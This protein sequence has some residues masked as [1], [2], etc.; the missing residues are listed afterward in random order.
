MGKMENEILKFCFEKGLLVDKDIL[1][2]F[3]EEDI[4]FVKIFIEKIKNTTHQNV[5]TKNILVNNKEKVDNLFLSF[6]KENQKVI[7]KLKIKL[8]LSIEISKE[9]SLESSKSINKSEENNI[10]KTFERPAE[11]I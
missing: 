7:E 5:I 9:L 1:E 2:L 4:N 11:N 6:P 8:G 10:V 3:K